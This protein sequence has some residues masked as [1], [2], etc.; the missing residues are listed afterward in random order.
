M[1][2]YIYIYTI[3]YYILFICLKAEDEQP[4]SKSVKESEKA[5]VGMNGT[6]RSKK[7]TGMFVHQFSDW[8]LQ[9]RP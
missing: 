3:I 8:S 9:S 6:G 2:I 7:Q 4:V 5:S 1:Y